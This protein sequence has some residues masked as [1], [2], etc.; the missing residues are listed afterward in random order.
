MRA[1]ICL[2]TVLFTLLSASATANEFSHVSDEELAEELIARGGDIDRT[3]ERIRALDVEELEIAVSLDE[4]Q[5]RVRLIDQRLTERVGLLYRLSRHGTALRYL[6]SVGSATELLKRLRALR[7]LVIDG[8]EDR[9][10]AGL[11]V[12]QLEE[13]L[14]SVGDEQQRATEMLSTLES[15]R[16]DLLAEQHRRAGRSSSRSGR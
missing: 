2:T 1:A 5:S 10:L 14:R 15:T 3:R 16:D 4:A 6:V 9:R 13:R 11:R 12:A 7:H 8:L